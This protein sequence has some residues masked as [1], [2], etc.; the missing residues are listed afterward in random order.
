MLR[1]W[2]YGACCFVRLPGKS[3]KS[4]WVIM[5]TLIKEETKG[6]I[7]IVGGYMFIAARP[8]CEHQL[9]EIVEKMKSLCG[10]CKGEK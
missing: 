2:C 1:F 5:L 7:E 3:D 9:I 6:V 4:K 10:T 8:L